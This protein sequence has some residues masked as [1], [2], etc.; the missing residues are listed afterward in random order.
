MSEKQES[1]NTVETKLTVKPYTDMST[2]EAALYFEKEMWRWRALYSDLKP[3][4]GR[5]IKD[6]RTLV[7]G[8]KQK[9]A[10]TE[11]LDAAVNKLNLLEQS[12]GSIRHE[13]VGGVK[14]GNRLQALE[15][16][17][18]M[19]EKG[20]GDEREKGEPVEEEGAT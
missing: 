9:K 1:V 2:F 15:N 12:L 13:A 6:N 5:L 10:D 18:G 16:I 19:I 4:F 8:L 11:L 14:N 17:I 7:E 3:E 20:D